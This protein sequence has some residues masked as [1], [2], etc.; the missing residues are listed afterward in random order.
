VFVRKLSDCS[1]SIS[2]VYIL[3]PSNANLYGLLKILLLMQVTNY[4]PI[5]YEVGAVA[6]GSQ[7][8]TPPDL[9]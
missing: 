2:I 4:N 6:L 3:L 9:S 7:P 5:I 8:Q 1:K